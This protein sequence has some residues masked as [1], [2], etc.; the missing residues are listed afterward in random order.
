LVVADVDPAGAQKTAAMAESLGRRAIPVEC[1]VMDAGQL[2]SAVSRAQRELGRIDILVNNAGGVR[3]S[4]FLEQS[5]RSWQRHIDLN[6]SS[7]LVATKAAAAVMIDGGRGGSIVNV[8]TIE[9][10]RAAPGYAV[11]A[12]CKAAV[13]SFTQSMALELAEHGIRVN[14]ISP[15][16]TRTPGTLG[17]TG[18]DVPEELPEPSPMEQER[19]ARYVPLGRQGTIEECGAVVAFLCSPLA[20][21]V[22]GINVPVDGGTRASSGW[23]RSASGRWTLVGE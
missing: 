16:L 2:R 19:A 20:S 6:L 3:P 23:L 10:T 14:V 21:Y 17:L 4:R 15:D 9:A 13:I 12:A 1:D 8:S 22:T 7:V 5:E 18:H 11:Y